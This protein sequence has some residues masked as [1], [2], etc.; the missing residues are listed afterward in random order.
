MRN[1]FYSIILVICTSCG[2]F[3]EPQSQTEYVPRDIVA[4]NE[5]LIGNAYI[6]PNVAN[7]AIFSL[8]EIFSDDWS[9]TSENGNNTNNLKV[10]TDMKPFYSWH[11]EM[12]IKASDNGKYS[13]VWKN[14]YQQILGCN[15]VLD[16]LDKVTGTQIDKNFV[17]GQALALRAFYYFQLV[18]LFGEPYTYNRKALG[19]PLKLNSGLDLDFPPRA[20]VE[21]VYQQI[22]NDLSA[23]ETAYLTL[24][25]D[26]QFPKDGRVTLPMIQLNKARLALF[27]EDYASVIRYSKMV[28]QDWGLKLLDLNTVV[29]T[30]AQP[31]YPFT[32][33]DNPESIWLFGASSDFNRYVVS[34][35]IYTTPTSSSASARRLFQASPTLVNSFAVNDLRKSQYILRESLT[36]SHLL[37]SG[38]IP[39]NS[40][41]GV[42]ST[43]FG[44]SLRVSEA[45][46]MLAE[47]YYHTQ[48]N[49][50]AVNTLEQLRQRR[51]KTGSGD[52]Y[53][54]PSGQVSGDGLLAFIKEERRRE[55]CYE[56]LRWFDQRR[57]GM[58]SFTRIWKEEG[59]VSEFKMEKNDPAF[60]L[61][62][63][64]DAI[65]K[66]RNLLQ[67][68][69]A[70]P[71]Y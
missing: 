48:Q 33:Y 40:S 25:T 22:H 20:T 55:M 47:A 5:L 13:G 4:L 35:F 24:P 36:I 60:T 44:R 26:R 57:Y 38:K 11:P 50:E 58:E 65:E 32:I 23:A 37:P 62:V 17:R 46:L 18:N 53:K 7:M 10:Y 71:K 63:P 42:V 52:Q 70:N 66:N 28:I 59:V 31:Y 21:Q 54:V 19:V 9:V 1:I 61:P 8:H 3:L 69:L 45:Y 51:F 14:T 49:Q 29:N 64:F 27:M 56:G 43:R 41:L 39:V 12:F 67:N 6:D 68:T 2:D 30:A 34:E 15:A 16:Y